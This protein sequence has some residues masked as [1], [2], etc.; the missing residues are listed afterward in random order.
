MSSQ[1]LKAFLQKYGET[2]TD[3]DA[4]ELIGLGDVDGDGM[5][6]VEEFIRALQEFD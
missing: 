6:N 5:L 3:E 1:E 4:E 2:L